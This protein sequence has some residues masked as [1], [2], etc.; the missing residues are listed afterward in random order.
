[1]ATGIIYVMSTVVDGLIKIGRTGELN[2]EQRIYNLERNGYFNVTGLKRRFAI[3]VEDYDEKEQLLDEIFSKSRVPNSELF[4]LDIDLVIQLLSSFEGTQVYP[5][6]ETKEESFDKA[7]A[8]HKEHVEAS[9][10]PDGTYYLKRRMKKDGNKLWTA[11]MFAHNGKFTIPA[12]EHISMIEGVG[13]QDNVR[14][15]RVGCAD[16]NGLVLQDATFDSLSSAGSFVVG[17]SCDGWMTWRD[18]DGVTLDHYRKAKSS[19]K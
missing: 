8:E 5:Q 6:T 16:E 7:T 10:I 18:A 11:K 4:A 9:L 15:V 3:K 19:E 17:A 13:L 2:F 1:M 14:Q 12:G